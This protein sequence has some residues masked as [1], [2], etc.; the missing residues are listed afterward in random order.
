MNRN[1]QTHTPM[2]RLSNSLKFEPKIL[3]RF[4]MS[5]YDLVQLIK[6]NRSV[7]YDRFIESISYRHPKFNGTNHFNELL[8][9]KKIISHSIY[10][11]RRDEWLNDNDKRAWLLIYEPRRQ[12]NIS[13]E[14]KFLFSLFVIHNSV[15][16]VV[17]VM[18]A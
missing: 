9:N 16:P 13:V 10:F 14:Q 1:I 12:T 5:W 18:H 17:K 6:N 8:K 2:R 4:I 15:Q 11:I 7:W 3:K